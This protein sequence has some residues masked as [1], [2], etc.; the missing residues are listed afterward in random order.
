MMTDTAEIRLETST[1][2]NFN[3]VVCARDALTRKPAFM[4]GPL[5][6]AIVDKVRRELPSVSVIT[7]SGFGEF[8]L[9]PDWRRK[10]AYAHDRFDKIHIVT[11]L[12]VLDHDDLRF[13]LAHVSDI[14]VSVYGCDDAV[15]RAVHR[16][17]PS[18]TEAAIRSKVLYMMAAKRADQTVILNY[19][20]CDANRHQTQE[21]IRYWEPRV[22]L[23]EVWRPHNWIYAKA[24][25]PLTPER[26]PTCGRP[27]KGPIQVQV[28]GT[29]NVCCFDFNGDMLIG[30][31][32]GQGFRE[33]FGGAAMERIQALHASGRADEL[34][35]C[36]RC[37]QRNAAS[38][39]GLALIHNSRFSAHERVG[40]TSTEY[41]QLREDR[42][43]GDIHRQRGPR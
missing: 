39:A 41:D 34:A 43:H 23:I 36:A 2:C 5:F 12:S 7:L 11:N 38:S 10:V 6:D 29:V 21:W 20:E 37:D 31:L 30:D 24:Y 16:P 14:R 15:Y 35:L 33:I 4:P 9:D 8:S 19:L 26:Q 22:D 1:A 42:R 17:P 27:F 13:L 3:C 25:R 28:D 18:I 32:A 40:A